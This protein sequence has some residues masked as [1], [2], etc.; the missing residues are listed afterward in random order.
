MLQL[1]PAGGVQQDQQEQI[2]SLAKARPHTR[3]EED[4]YVVPGDDDDGDDDDGFR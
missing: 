3:M 4:D 1:S 2:A